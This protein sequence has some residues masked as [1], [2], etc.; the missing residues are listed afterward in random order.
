VLLHDTAGTVELPQPGRA[1]HADADGRADWLWGPIEI[2]AVATTV[3]QVGAWSE[4]AAASE[5]SARLAA[6]LGEAA[7]ITTHPTD[8]GLVRVR[9]GWPD[10]APG[11]ARERL[12]ALGFD[13][14]FA[15]SSS[16][17]IRVTGASASFEAEGELLL[18]PADDWPVVVGSRSYRGRLRLRSG[19]DGLRVINELPLES[20]LRG[21][22]PVEMGPYQFPE[23]EALKAQAVAART[24]AV[25]HL[26][27]HDAEGWDIC[28]TP[29]CQAYHGAGSEHPL[30][31]RAVRETAGRIATY[32]GAPIDAMYTSTCGGHTE[33]AALLFPDRTQPYLMGVVCGWDRELRIAGTDPSGAWIDRLEFRADTVRTALALDRSATP[34]ELIRR[35]N[36]LSG[37]AVHLVAP[38]GPDSYAIALL[39]AAGIETPPAFVGGSTGLEKL[40]ELADLFELDLP[41]P[42][43]GLAGAWP[44]AAALTVLELRGDVVRDHGEA[45]PHPRGAAI[46]PRRADASEPLPSP[47]PLW[48]R[49]AGGYRRLDEA[50]L[51]PGTELERIRFGDRVIAVVIRRSGGAGE[52]DRR[53]AWRSWVRERDWSVLA[54]SIGIAD[55]ERLAVTRRGVSGRV[56]EM[57]AHGRSGN[58]TL[59]GF[60]IR[61]TLDLP[62]TLFTMQLIRRPDGGRS[63]RFLG[64]GWGHGVGLCQN[65]A[66]GLARAGMT[67]D[68]I[69]MHYYTGVSLEP[70]KTD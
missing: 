22:V 10:G 25:A 30:S 5:V 39:A 67:F 1:Y 68:Q 29:A 48:E 23:L 56:V 50:G 11:D 47:A 4:V 18:T 37:L 16:G 2:Q 49:W 64:R 8:A 53:S 44:A 59:E 9:V 54:R 69:L 14:A 28:A 19:G 46:Y 12:A 65:G 66:Y 27:D 3:W 26:G 52:A 63:V 33:D 17:V 15:I 62:E 60:G 20:Y 6:E 36:D 7:R 38:L 21:V 42:T 13:D 24:Y 40:L 51:M 61:R 34:A 31:D 55:L 41:P 32:D 58:T 43:D 70:W 45:V 57:T 35:V